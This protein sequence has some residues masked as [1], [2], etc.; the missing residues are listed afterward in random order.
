MEDSSLD[1]KTAFL[2]GDRKKL[3]SNL[4]EI[5]FL[6]CVHEKAV[7][8]KVSN[9]EFI[10]IAVY[11]DDIFMTGTSLDLINEFQREWLLNLKCRIL[12]R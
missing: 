12:V 10:I 2:N 11:R 9:E 6:Q 3:D 7:Y 8:R 5:G 4:E 1:V